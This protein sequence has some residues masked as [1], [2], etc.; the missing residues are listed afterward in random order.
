MDDDTPA[1]PFGQM[2]AAAVALHDLLVSLIAAGFSEG[3]ALYLVG[4]MVT[5]PKPPGSP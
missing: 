3:Q 2:A 5:A 1:D 4:V